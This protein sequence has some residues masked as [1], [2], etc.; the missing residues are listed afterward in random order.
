MSAV[1]GSNPGARPYSGKW[2]KLS[3]CGTRVQNH[4]FWTDDQGLAPCDFSSVS[5]HVISH[6]FP[7]FPQPLPSTC[8]SSLTLDLSSSLLLASPSCP[9]PGLSTLNDSPSPPTFPPF[10]RFSVLLR[11]FLCLLLSAC[12]LFAAARPASSSAKAVTFLNQKLTATFKC[13][14]GS[15]KD[16]TS[17][18]QKA[19]KYKHS[20]SFSSTL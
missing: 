14:S 5:A 11:S 2:S 4:Q 1:F 18:C 15:G 19:G 13:S 17:W 20:P 12:A 9:S 3:S 7:A 8:A 6:Y 16:L 10:Y